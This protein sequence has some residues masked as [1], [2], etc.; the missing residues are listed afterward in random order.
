MN[1]LEYSCTKRMD[2]KKFY[3]M[4]V[5]DLRLFCG[6]LDERQKWQIEIKDEFK[7]LPW[8]WDDFIN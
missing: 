1:D 4:F 7:G 8:T 5:L 6:S 2:K 3:K